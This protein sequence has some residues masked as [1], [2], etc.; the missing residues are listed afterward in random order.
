[1]LHILRYFSHSLKNVLNIRIVSNAYI[2]ADRVNRKFSFVKC[3]SQFHHLNFNIHHVFV[4]FSFSVSFL[5][6]ETKIT[7]ESHRFQKGNVQFS[8]A[9]IVKTLWK[10]KALSFV[11]E[12]EHR[13]THSKAQ[14]RLTKCTSIQYIIWELYFVSQQ[15]AFT[16]LTVNWP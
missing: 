3:V 12:H 9:F 13:H 14:L 15:I 8:C 7:S 5:L 4:V 10:T 16:I 11:S 1:M 6:C 2:F